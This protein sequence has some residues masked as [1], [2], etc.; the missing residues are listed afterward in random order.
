MSHRNTP[1]KPATD[2]QQ[3]VYRAILT[4]FAET[5][6]APTIRDLMARLDIKSPNGIA[7][8]LKALA[9][10]GLIQ[11]AEHTARGIEVAAI[12]GAVKATAERLMGD[13]VAV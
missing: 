7:C 11:T 10:R 5:G 3:E 4:H 9:Q 6:R 12:T 13:V 1:G 2:R 8:H